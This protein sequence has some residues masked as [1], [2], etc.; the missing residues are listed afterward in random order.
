MI[1]DWLQQ[2]H[3]AYPALL[4][5]LLLIPLLIVWYRIRGHRQ[6]SSIPVS[7]TGI[8]RR[9]ASGKYKMRHLPFA[10]RLVATGL[11]IVAMARPQSSNQEQRAEGEGIDIMLCLDVSGSM[12]AEDFLP[13]RLEAAKEV[14]AKFVQGRPTDRIG[15]VIFAGEPFTQCPLTSD[16]GVLLSQIYNIRSGMLQDGTAIGSGLA[17]SVERLKQS[18]SKS[19]VVILL[20][21]GEN[22]GGIIPPTTAKE[23]AKAFGIKVYTIGV[24]TEGYAL[25]PQ[26]TVTG[27]VRSREK[28]NIDERLLT[29][30]ATETGGRYFR[31]KD[32]EGLT[33]IYAGID[34]LE[35]SKIELTSYTRY[36]E[37]FYPLAL[38][39]LLLLV[40]EALLRYRVFRKFP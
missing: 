1:R 14:A 3:F 25:M 27:V 5:L 26:Q 6:Y 22:N 37:E 31:A 21:D 4:W 19:K 13:N 39:A 12:L 29:E 8:Y 23:I 10:I 24:G 17:T 40:L 33:A 28:V 32:N 2:I 18:D 11:L 34:Q 20:T 30:I 16:K 7:T 15:L 35:K 38:A 36:A 9:I